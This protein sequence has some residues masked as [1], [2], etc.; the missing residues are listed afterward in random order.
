[1]WYADCGTN[2]LLTIVQAIERIKMKKQ[3]LK[4]VVRANCLLFVT[5]LFVSMA[6]APVRAQKMPNNLSVS[7]D[8]TLRVQ[9]DRA[10]VRFGIVTVDEDAEDARRQNAADAAKTMNA[11]RALK[12]EDRKI[13]LETLQLQ[14]HQEYDPKLN[15]RV[16]RGY[17][18]IRSVVVEVDDLDVLP[19]LVAHV[20]GQGANRLSGI[21][22][23]L[24][25]RQS[26]E[27]E[28]LRKAVLRAKEKAQLMATTLGVA[29]GKVIQIQEQGVTI[30]RPRLEMGST[31]VASK[32]MDAGTPE[33]FAS[34]EIEV[35]ATV[36]IVFALDQ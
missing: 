35:R 1:V 26:V 28:V 9:P 24:R 2:T 14:P 7:G 5:A 22:Y 31:M 34:G 6:A 4:S 12:I 20:V 36:R 8:G 13:R 18:A 23:D 21:A 27:D 30:P 17:E 10:M 3:V 29:V 16:N 15:R 25:D 19:K 11:V 32:N 33:A